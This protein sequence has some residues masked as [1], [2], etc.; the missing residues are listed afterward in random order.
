MRTVKTICAWLLILGSILI[1]LM[2]IA[3]DGAATPQYF[4]PKGGGGSGGITGPTGV[5]GNTGATGGANVNSNSIFSSVTSAGPNNSASETSLIGTVVGSQTI[6]A[7]TL[8]S[9][10]TIQVFATGLLNTPVSASNLTL[11]IYCG[12]TAI[13]QTTAT[14]PGNNVSNGGFTLSTI[15]TAQGSGAGGSISQSGNVILNGATT[16]IR[17]LSILNPT[18]GTPVPFDFTTACS[19]DVKAT[20][21][22]AQASQFLT[23]TNVAAWYVRQ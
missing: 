20:W 12:A 9:G 16:T 22:A 14:S 5:T 18:P 10:T 15:L 21:S 1:S 6:A 4:P 8:V 7:N 3:R 17:A 19:L 13:G 23:G 11:K 2:L